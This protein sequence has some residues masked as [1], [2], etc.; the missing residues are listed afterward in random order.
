MKSCNFQAVVAA[1]VFFAMGLPS[2]CRGQTTST[3]CPPQ[4]SILWPRTNHWW[5]NAFA[6]GTS[7]KIKANATDQDGTI[8]EVRFYAEINP[9]CENTGGAT[10]A[11]SQCSAR[12]NLLGVVTNAP[13]NVVWDLWLPGIGNAFI[14][15]KAV[16]KDDSGAKT[17]SSAVMIYYSGT[18]PPLT[19]LE[20]V[21]PRDGAL[22]PAP[23]TFAFATELLAVYGN[24]RLEFFV[25]TN[26][27]GLETVSLSATAPPTSI[28]VS[29]LAEGEYK[30]SLQDR[31]SVGY[32]S[33]NYITNTVRV[34][35]L[36]V[37]SAS[38]TLD[39]RLQLEIVT[40]FPGRDTIIQASS[41]LLEWSPLSTNQPSTNT[42]TFTE[43]SP[44]TNAQRFYRVFLPPE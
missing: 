13:F 7:I 29:N 43:S 26:S 19:V 1:L 23:A 38:M 3:N 16:A 25:G 39:G 30:L 21:S 17:E 10:T 20:I 27:V 41:N 14:N 44:A 32:C 8:G 36:G 37:Q 2:L 11:Q 33:C 42:F 31:N 28:I 6:G 40:S 18:R 35:Q 24:A 22:L 15:L 9:L 4:I 12:T 5:D 34:V